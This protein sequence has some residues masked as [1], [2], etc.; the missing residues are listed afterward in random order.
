MAGL[1]IKRSRLVP[2]PRLGKVEKDKSAGEQGM[3]FAFPPRAEGAGGGEAG[4]CGVERS[5]L[6]LGCPP[7]VCE[8]GV[9]AVLSIDP[10]KW[11]AGRENVETGG[12]RTGSGKDS[13][14]RGWGQRDDGE[15]KK[16]AVGGGSQQLPLPGLHINEQ[17]CPLWAKRGKSLLSMEPANILRVWG[18]SAIPFN[19]Q[20]LGKDCCLT[21]KPRQ[22]FKLGQ[23]A[24]AFPFPL[25]ALFKINFSSGKN[26]LIQLPSRTEGKPRS[27]N[28]QDKCR[29]LFPDTT[30]R[31]F[32]L[33]HF[34]CALFSRRDSVLHSIMFKALLCSRC[35]ISSHEI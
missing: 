14:G 15:G 26:H 35:L 27:R 29:L 23:M 13:T 31:V 30:A 22:V 1:C 25:S 20:P 10:E 32:F 24:R 9:G 3:L 16:R 21:V 28:T 2:C 11:R 12:K 8:V 6:L 18:F 19:T 5:H 4:V 7:A 33:G 34:V 17:G